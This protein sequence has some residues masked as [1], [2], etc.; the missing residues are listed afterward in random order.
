MKKTN[1]ETCKAQFEY[2]PVTL[3]GKELFPRRYCDTCT[4]SAIAN[5]EAQEREIKRRERESEWERVCAPSYRM[6]D[7]QHPSLA[8]AALRMCIAWD[9]P[10]GIGLMGDT[11][12]GKTRCLFLALR[13]AFDA[14]K[15]VEFVSHNAFSRIAAT[16]YSGDG[17]EKKDALNSIKRFSSVAVLLLD[18]LGK[19]PSTERADAEMEELIEHRTSHGLPI[20]WSANG[21]GEWISARFG[22]DRGPA[23]VRRLAEF[24]DCI[25][26]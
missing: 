8:Q 15:P 14:G 13:R 2:V 5:S 23:F 3:G 6:T 4:A 21:Y 25:N 12:V 22:K 1:C 17:N 20:L 9:G 19:A 18:D 11:G 16:A 10:R 7:P 24:S 26:L